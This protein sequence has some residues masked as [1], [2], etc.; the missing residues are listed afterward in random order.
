[1]KPLYLYASLLAVLFFVLS[2]RTIRLRR[3]LKIGVG[4]AGSQ[5]MLRAMRVHSN[6]SEYVPLCLF[7][8]FLVESAGANPGIIHMLGATLLVGRLSHAYGVSQVKENFRFRVTG[9]TLTFA[10]LLGCAA[11]LLLSFIVNGG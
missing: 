3:K 6:F 11:Y 5:Q 1:M 9:M 7:L 4:D 2:A 8:I 10:V